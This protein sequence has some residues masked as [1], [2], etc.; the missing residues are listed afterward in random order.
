ADEVTDR[1]RDLA[2][3][4][5]RPHGVDLAIRIGVDTGDVIAPTE[6]RPGDPAVT[7]DARNVASRLQSAA[8]PGGVL[9]GDRTFQATREL[10]TF[11]DPTELQLKGKSSPVK[12]HSLIGR[13]EGALERGPARNL[14]AR[15]V[16]REREL[17]VLGG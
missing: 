4:V 14:R 8:A 15:V 13:I 17:A 16:G 6:P 5:Q 2:A 11:D 7:G 12:A 10:F 3:D 9:V 1:V